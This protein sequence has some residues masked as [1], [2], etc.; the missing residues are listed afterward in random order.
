MKYLLFILLNVLFWQIGFAQNVSID[1]SFNSNDACIYGEGADYYVNVSAKQ[2]DGK[3]II[4]G[5]FSTYNGVNVNHIVRLNTDGSI[6]NSF[7]IGNSFEGGTNTNVKSIV[8][9]NDG[10][11]LV[12]GFFSSFNG[13]T[14]NNIAR[15]NPDGTLDN[16]FNVGTGFD[17]EVNSIALQ[18]DGKIIVGGYFNTF[19][20]VS[21]VYLIRLNQNGTKDNSFNIGTGTNNVVNTISVQSDDKIILG[22]YFSSYNGFS[23]NYMV[24]LNQDGIIDPTFSIGTGFSTA[25]FALKIQQ[26]GKIIVGGNFNSFMEM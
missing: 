16:T 10:K 15:L 11:I 7:N 12:G 14:T 6:D 8:I 20:G 13:T 23:S 5:G 26:D 4:G 18:S 25:V 19:C 22:G 3:I 21:S 17:T 1:T 24:R 2:Q 9:Q